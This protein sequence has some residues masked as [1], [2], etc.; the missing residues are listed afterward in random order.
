MSKKKAGDTPLSQKI[1]E[2]L[3]KSRKKVS[4]EDLSNRFQVP[5]GVIDE[6]VETLRAEGKNIDSKYGVELVRDTPT[7]EP[8]KIDISKFKGQKIVLGLTADNHLGSKYARMDVLNALYDI[9]AEQ[10]VTQV[11]Q[12]GNMIDGEA[13]FNR[14]DLMIPPGVEAQVDYF[15]EN[16]PKRE[17]ITT[18]FVAGDDHEGWYVRDFGLDIGR[19]M[20]S[21]ARE[22]GRSDLVFLNYMEHDVIFR[23][24]HGEAV[25]RV[26]H[27]GGG[28]AYAT[29]YTMQKYVE[30][31]QGGEKPAIVLAGHYHKA[32]YGYPREIHCVQAG[33]SQDQTPFMR[34]KKIAAHVGGWTISFVVDDHGL[35]HEFTPQFHPF[36]DRGFYTGENKWKYHW[37]QPSRGKS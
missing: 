13:R 11:Y 7:L 8:T 25:M 15:V 32:E 34:K 36:Y 28:S 3:R 23:A 27:A 9:W 26:I 4:R 2:Y 12:A 30:A 22:A 37:K 5:I 10:G 31:L 24:K 35:V 18:Y 33:C 29:S 14:H 16:W 17:G 1:Y 19:M 20:E 6:A 21:R